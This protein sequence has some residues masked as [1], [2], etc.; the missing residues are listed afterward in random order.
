MT[1]RS[2]VIEGTADGEVSGPRPVDRGDASD[3]SVGEFATVVPIRIAIVH[4]RG[5]VPDAE[6]SVSSAGHGIV[7]APRRRGV[8]P[9]LFVIEPE[10][11]PKLVDGYRA[12]AIFAGRLAVR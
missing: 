11:V 2:L 5:L 1:R 10:N 6:G 8:S 3:V 7:C 4:D 9:V 12:N